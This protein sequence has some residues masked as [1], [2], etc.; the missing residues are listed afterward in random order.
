MKHCLAWP[1]QDTFSFCYT[2]VA[3][4]SKS[5]ESIIFTKKNVIGSRYC[6]LLM[7]QTPK[8]HAYHLSTLQLSIIH[9][10]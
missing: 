4:V 7:T 9:F 5:P 1:F 8:L 10:N 6:E 3:H 2:D